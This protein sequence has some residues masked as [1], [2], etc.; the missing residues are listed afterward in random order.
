MKRIAI[1][2]EGTYGFITST[3]ISELA[4]IFEGM[5]EEVVLCQFTCYGNW[6]KEETQ[7]IGE[8]SIFDLPDLSRF[9]GII[10]DT[11]SIIDMAKVEHIIR[12]AKTSNIPVISVGF[13]VDG[14]YY[15]GIDNSKAIR[16]VMEHLYYGHNCRSFVFAGGRIGNSENS[17]RSIAYKEFLLDHCLDIKDN[18]VLMEDFTFNTGRHHFERIVSKNFPLP[19]AF[20]CADD[21]IAA[22]LIY[23]AKLRGYSVPE[24]FFVTGFDDTDAAKYYEPQISTV[25]VDKRR[26]AGMCAEIFIKA[27]SGE[28]VQ[29]YNYLETSV[30]KAESCGCD[31]RKDTDF[32]AY[33]KD[34]IL[35]GINQIDRYGRINI[36]ET[37]LSRCD[38]F[39]GIFKKASELI[40]NLGAREVNFFIDE[41][42][43]KTDIE[44]KFDKDNYNWK[45]IK[46]AFSTASYKTAQFSNF[47]EVLEMLS[48][49]KR[50]SCF[51]FLPIHFHDV[52]VGFS[53]IENISVCEEH[54]ILYNYFENFCKVV[55]S[56]YY[57]KMLEKTNEHLNDMYIRDMMT[58][59]Y[60]RVAF[61]E[62]IAPSLAHFHKMGVQCA[63]E[64]LDTDDFKKIND[65]YGHIYGDRVLK[66]IASTLKE[67]CPE[68]GFVCR[69]GG[70]EFVVFFPL[71]EGVTA[72]GYYSDIKA[73]LIKDNIS[74]SV[75]YTITNPASSNG[76]DEYIL[77]ADKEM[78]AE[79][80]KKHSTR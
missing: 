61:T 57:K 42:L 10:L 40:I 25:H 19:D 9:D 58:G 45:K 47:S 73:A 74:V 24:D 29:E 44:Y 13:N 22:G 65:E 78:Y 15:V 12:M 3:H 76:F 26:L 2:S 75:G 79:K 20:V 53:A 21:Y 16:D 33:A 64:F 77:E 48:A 52:I 27:W 36:F 41:N 46:L 50:N 28:K 31:L 54:S 35:E 71:N 30:M 34:N 62:L 6:A 67:F 68:S 49:N 1:L 69:F 5:G 4:W 66:I 14:F 39:E 32:R 70:D 7:N 8:Y 11:N 72:E 37:E 55:F 43:F 56:L 17:I 63:I 51:M 59:A 23:E 18:P 60:N 38:T 80:Q